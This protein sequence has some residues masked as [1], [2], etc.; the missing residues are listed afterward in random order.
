MRRGLELVLLCLATRLCVSWKMARPGSATRLPA[1]W[2][3]VNGFQEDVQSPQ[4]E[5]RS[6]LKKSLQL[7]LVGATTLLKPVEGSSAAVLVEEGAKGYR[8][9]RSPYSPSQ[10]LLYSPPLLPQSALI[11]SLPVPNALVGEIQAYVESFI[12]LLNPTPEQIR[13]IDRNN[14]ILWNNLRINAQRA[15]GMFIYNRESL[16]PPSDEGPGAETKEK[17]AMRQRFSELRLSTLQSDLLRLV[18]ASRR[19]S[20]SD[21]LRCMRYAL[22]SLHSAAYL[23][24]PP[25]VIRDIS[26]ANA[27]A[28]AKELS[29][30]LPVTVSSAEGSTTSSGKRR[31]GVDAKGAAIGFGSGPSLPRLEGR[32][33]VTLEFRRLSKGTNDR[34]LVRIVVDGIHHPVAGGSFVELVKAG[35]YDGTVVQAGQFEFPDGG[36]QRLLLGLPAASPSASLM[37]FQASRALRPLE[38]LRENSKDRRRFTAYGAARNSAVFTGASESTALDESSQ[39]PTVNSFATYG[40]IGAF[41]PREDSNAAA[42]EFFVVPQDPSLTVSERHASPVIAKLNSRYSLLGYC[43][44]RNDVLQ[45]LSTGDVLTSASVE[46]GVWN[47]VS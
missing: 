8:A 10:S 27:N 16:L 20:V 44:D 11:N 47:L 21:S 30:L 23:A 5:Y 3:V 37:T 40:A 26:A 42:Q 31:T 25:R 32:C 36:V 12:Q 43:I 24:V 14:S 39:S 33:V 28:L 15:A 4:S 45:R 9:V 2:S 6:R 29:T 46:E 34:A 1:L 13:Q 35:K 19:S 38:I 22:N 7:T 41:H 17:Q 18:N